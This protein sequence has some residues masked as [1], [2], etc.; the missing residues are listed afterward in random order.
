[1]LEKNE[2]GKFETLVEKLVQQELRLYI[3]KLCLLVNKV[4][5]KNFQSLLPGSDREFFLSCIGAIEAYSGRAYLLF[6]SNY[7]IVQQ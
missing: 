4:L 1:M 6:Y 7:S 5:E 2:N 3:F